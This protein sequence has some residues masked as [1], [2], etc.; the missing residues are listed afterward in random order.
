[1]QTYI[2]F[3]MCDHACLFAADTGVMAPI[4]SCPRVRRGNAG[5]F[6]SPSTRTFPFSRQK[7]HQAV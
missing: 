2:Y 4:V 6:P 1:M 3:E 5:L 7:Q